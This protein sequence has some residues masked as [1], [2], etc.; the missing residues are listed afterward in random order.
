M[1]KSVVNSVHSLHPHWQQQLAEAITDPHE[2]LSLLQL[3]ADDFPNYLLGSLDFP[4]RVPRAFVQKIKRADPRDPLLLQVMSQGRERDQIP[5]YH[6]DPVGDLDAM[7][8]PGLLHKY[9]GRVLLVTTGACAVHCRYCFRRHFPYSEHHPGRHDWQQAMDYI[10]QHADIHEV[11]LSGGDPLV[12]SDPKLGRLI[13]MI[14]DIPHIR[15]LRLHSRLPVVLPDR[16]TPELTE[17][18]NRS[19]LN[20]CLVIHA[21]HAREIGPD[22]ASALARLHRSV[23]PRLPAGPGTGRGTFSCRQISCS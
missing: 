14:E 5:G 1:P 6:A 22:E 12:L 8:V 18:L 9:Q 23:W 19:R 4:L 2:L 11:I 20:V 21:N 3:S 16:I 17:L 15:R 7:A 13:T 10:R